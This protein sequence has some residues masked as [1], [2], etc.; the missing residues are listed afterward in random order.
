MLAS[1]NFQRISYLRNLA[2]FRNIIR[3]FQYDNFLWMKRNMRVE[4][5]FK[6]TE[7]S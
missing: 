3:S 5:Y 1:S 7:V 6:L 4:F 2:Q